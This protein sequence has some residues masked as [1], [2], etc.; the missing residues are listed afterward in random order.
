M[1]SR[2]ATAILAVGI[3]MSASG[4]AR[5]D[6]IPGLEAAFSLDGVIG[7]GALTATLGNAVTLAQHRPARGWIYT[8]LIS[9]ALNLVAGLVTLGYGG[10]PIMRDGNHSCHDPDTMMDYP[11]GPPTPALRWGLGMSQTLLAIADLG[12]S[13]AAAVAWQRRR[14]ADRPAPTAKQ[15]LL[16][17]I[18]AGRDRSGASI[19]GMA[20][21]V[22]F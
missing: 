10:G 22:D 2:F 4:R 12:V 20:F 15:L 5:A 18:I 19:Y 16:P 7:A 17:R 13:I 8:G 9:G 21:A 6:L 3:S 14:A 11:C 1:R